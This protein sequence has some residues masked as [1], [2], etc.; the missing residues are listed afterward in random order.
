MPNQQENEIRN[1]IDQSRKE[2]NLL[3]D[4]LIK[5]KYRVK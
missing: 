3:Q 4:R 5:K 1:E 2:I